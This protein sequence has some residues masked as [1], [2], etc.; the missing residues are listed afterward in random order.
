MKKL[1]EI[2]AKSQ[3]SV[4]VSQSADDKIDDVK[5]QIQNLSSNKG[6]AATNNKNNQGNKQ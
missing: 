6:G 1:K 2:E 5:K 4:K 3:Q